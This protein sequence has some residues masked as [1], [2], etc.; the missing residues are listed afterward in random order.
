MKKI[1]LFSLS[2]LI[3]A[4]FSGCFPFHHHGHGHAGPGNNQPMHR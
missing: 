3:A 2:I 1:Y 4:V